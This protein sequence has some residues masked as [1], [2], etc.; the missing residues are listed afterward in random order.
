M[1][2]H[3]MSWCQKKKSFIVRRK[4]THWHK[5]AAIVQDRIALH[6]ASSP[7]QHLEV[8][9]F[10]DGNRDTCED[11]WPAVVLVESPFLLPVA[12]CT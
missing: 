12:S 9:S 6:A 4:D 10:V 2:T 8:Q 11:T 3:L 1:I 7:L 5:D